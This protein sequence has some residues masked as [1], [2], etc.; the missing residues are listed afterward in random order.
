MNEVRSQG[1]YYEIGLHNGK[2]LIDQKKQGFPPTF[3][4]ENLE[5]A[6][7]Y[8]DAVQT[9]CP[10]LLDELQGTAESCDVDYPTLVAFELTPYRLQPSCL[11]FAV[12]GDH[13]AS[14]RSLFVRNHEWMEEESK[15][16]TVCTV[17][18]KGKLASYGF[19]FSWPLLSRYGGI[20]KAGLAISGATTSFKNKGPGVMMNVAMRWIL[21]T[22]KTTEEAVEFIKEIPKVWGNNYLIIDRHNTLVKIEAHREKTLITYTDTGFDM[23]SL[24]NEAPEMRELNKDEE[25]HMIEQFEVRRRFLD[26]WFAEH[27]GSITEQTIIDVLKPCEN[28]LHYHEKTSQGTLGTC[29]SWIVSPQSHEVLISQGPPCKTPFK[30]QTIEYTFSAE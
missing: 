15:Y 5:R 30:P 3:S 19:T 16:L 28:P 9:H 22:F 1:S 10:G 6:K 20:N 4:K 25:P 18:P 13:T 21:D 7:P 11:V 23:V 14:G 24:T 27:K 17:H 8:G 26:Q 29:W 12:T 2:Q